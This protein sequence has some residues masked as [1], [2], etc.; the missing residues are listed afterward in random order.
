[1]KEKWDM[2]LR[3]LGMLLRSK[4]GDTLTLADSPAE[5]CFLVI[6][7]FALW[8]LVDFI[9]LDTSDYEKLKKSVGNFA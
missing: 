3:V 4:I 6:K 8:Y 9:H 7:K 1:M 2:W 5:R